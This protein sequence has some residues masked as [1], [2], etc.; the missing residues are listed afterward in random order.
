MSVCMY[1]LRPI[2]SHDETLPPPSHN[3]YTMKLVQGNEGHPRSATVRLA[4]IT[5][6]VQELT[7]VRGDS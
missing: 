7:Q 1:K 5:D 4:D 6:R 2:V 3:M